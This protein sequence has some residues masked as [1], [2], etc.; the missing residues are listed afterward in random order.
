MS[1]NLYRGSLPSLYRYAASLGLLFLKTGFIIAIAST[2]VRADMLTLLAVYDGS[3]DFLVELEVTG[4]AGAYDAI[5]V[6]TAA[7]TQALEPDDGEVQWDFQSGGVSLDAMNTFYTS[8]ITFRFFTNGG[9]TESIYSVSAPAASPLTATDFPAPATDLG[10]TLSADPQRP[11]ATWTGGDSTANL[12]FLTYQDL[13][14][15]DEFGDPP[16]NPSMD[17]TSYTLQQDL[18]PG[19]YEATLGYWALFSNPSLSLVS[20]PDVFSPASDEINFLLVGATYYSPVDIAPIPVPAAAW[21]FG[22]A[23]GLLGWMRRRQN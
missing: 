21:L 18:M 22:S 10:V 2:A 1:M 16:L 12:L 6:D 4:A 7:G 19:T 20:G 11:T 13:D 9:S 5:G 17:P 23:L 15:L 3:S 14:T 8:P